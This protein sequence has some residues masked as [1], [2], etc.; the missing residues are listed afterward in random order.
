MR[1]YFAAISDFEPGRA[2][3]RGRRP[4]A[5]S[6]A[7]W[8][9][10]LRALRLE[11]GLDA[12]PA[13]ALDERGRPYFPDAPDIH[14]SLSHTR[15]FV[16]CALGEALVGADVQLIA[17]KDMPFARRLMDGREREDFTLHEL[18]CLRE[19]V[20][21]LTGA[22]DLRSMRFFRRGGDIVP[23]AEGVVCRLY[24]GIPG[25]AAAAAAY[26]PAELPERLTELGARELEETACD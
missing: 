20:Y 7:A 6:A 16:L 5:E 1:I 25:C 11:R 13:A 19:S 17:E 21:K 15:G 2:I 12:L 23:P 8:S 4:S 24:G 22:G 9:L 10:L 14:F 26:S 18:W 3:A